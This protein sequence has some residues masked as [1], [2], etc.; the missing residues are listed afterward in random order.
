[1]QSRK[2]FMNNVIMILSLVPPSLRK[3]HK[4]RYIK[5]RSIKAQNFIQKGAEELWREGMVLQQI[6]STNLH[7]AL[8]IIFLFTQVILF[9]N[10]ML[11]KGTCGHSLQ[12]R[13]KKKIKFQ[14]YH[15]QRIFHEF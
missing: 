8:I 5:T 10:V 1:M 14:I 6:T 2:V 12:K 3:S 15:K 9:H 13:N 7:L 4:S 11:E